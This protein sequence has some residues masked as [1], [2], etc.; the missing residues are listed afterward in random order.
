MAGGGGTGEEDRQR[1]REGG[2]RGLISFMKFL[3]SLPSYSP[4]ASP[5]NINHI[6][7]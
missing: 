7:S 1:K 4:K 2:G 3:L 6:G 5:A